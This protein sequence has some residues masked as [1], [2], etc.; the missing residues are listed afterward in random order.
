MKLF[1]WICVPLLSLTLAGCYYPAYPYAAGPDPYY[2]PAPAYYSGPAY[3]P[4]YPAVS[5]SVYIGGGSH[6]HWHRW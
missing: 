6:R 4:A 3:Y 5:G 2:P 1:P